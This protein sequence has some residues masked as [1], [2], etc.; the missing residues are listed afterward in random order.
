MKLFFNILKPFVFLVIVAVG[1]FVSDRERALEFMFGPM[2]NSPIDF[3]TLTLTE[4]P[5]QFLVCPA[6]FCS[7]DPMVEIGDFPLS[8][9]ELQARWQAVIAE[10]PRVELIA[11]DE[12][13]QQ[14][15]YVQ[16]SDLMRF[17]DT[18]TV[19]FISLGEGRST[20]AIY[21]RSHYGYSD[22]GAN[23]ARIEGWLSA[24]DL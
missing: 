8:V 4:K 16:R 23:Q 21:S 6:N 5:N 3:A 20:L 1:L 7:A 10:A 14:Y 11:K 13:E 22:L 15:D 24:L 19:K 2:D 18:I 9:A 17:P 12:A